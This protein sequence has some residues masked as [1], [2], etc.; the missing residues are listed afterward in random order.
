MLKRLKHLKTKKWFS[1]VT[2][3]YVIILSVFLIWMVFFDTNSFL[4]QREL[5]N[6]IKI[7]EAEKKYLKEE[8]NK[9]RVI[10]KQFSSQENLEK[11]ARET[12]LLK[13]K[14]EEVFLIEFQDSINQKENE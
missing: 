2:N 7:L 5:Q 8:I 10:L 13:K 1:V 14:N 4:I 11:F 6:Q 12:Y 3:L 9:D